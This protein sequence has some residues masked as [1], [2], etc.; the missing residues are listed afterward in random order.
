MHSSREDA[1]RSAADAPRDSGTAPDDGLTREED[2]AYDARVTAEPDGAAAG[3]GITIEPVEGDGDGVEADVE[4]PEPE[5][6]PEPPPD[7]SGRF[8]VMDTLRKL[9]RPRLSGGHGNRLVT[10]AVRNRLNE[11]GYE[12]K[13]HPFTYSAGPGRFGL[14]AAGAA[15]A[16]AA[17]AATI[18]ISLGYF[19]PA[20][21]VLAAGAGA[22]LAIA[23]FA[24]PMIT[25]LPWMRVE[26]TN[27]L[28]FPAGKRPRYI[29][30]AHLDSKSQLVPLSLRAPAI[31]LAVLSW[32]ALFAIALIA[33]VQPVD[34]TFV[35]IAGGIAFLAGIV[36]ML[37]WADDK[38]PGA[39][40]NA[41]GLT[42]LLGLA[43]S[44]RNS[45]DIGFLVTD[46]EELGLAGA[47]AVAPALPPVFGVFNLDGIDDDGPFHIIERF[48][49]KR[50]GLAPHMAA[51]LLAAAAD[52]KLPAD[53]RDLPYGV[54]VDHIPIVE[55]GLPALTIMR[56][57]MKSLRRVHRPGDTVD[58]MRGSGIER[59]IELMSD[60]LATL[61][62]QR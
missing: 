55:A 29:V 37:S 34:M 39:L 33:L 35:L 21:L 23:M 27:L 36:L 5:A 22:V 50:K 17:L 45:G 38:S 47:R 56:G 44:E 40:D 46:A 48:G 7:L 12:V 2:A 24:I 14:P 18:L 31:V 10:E 16:T 59:T 11:L 53:R 32:I 52:R 15:F 3:T 13:D 42:T 8:H 57:T 54:M 1:P 20:A 60:A 9:S 25:R 49:F 26:G 6:P 58:R 61:R 41:S 28:A 43:E 4:P 19:A 30:M 51:A 62:S